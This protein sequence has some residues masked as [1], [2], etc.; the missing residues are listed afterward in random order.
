MKKFYLFAAAATCLAIAC[1]IVETPAPEDA[2]LV[3]YI[4]ADGNENASKSS[5]S[6]SDASFSWNTG[7][8][9]AVH[10][11]AGYKI[12]DGLDGSYDGS[13]AATFAF[14]GANAIADES[15]RESFAIYPASLV[16][17]GT[18][19]LT[20]S[21]SDYTTS[22]LKLT[23]PS[24][25]ALAEVQDEVSPTPMIAVN[26]PDADLSFKALCP[27]LRITVQNIPKQTKRIE[28]NFN[29]Q[30]VQ[31][32]FTLTGVTPGTSAIATGATD[33]DDDIIRVTMAD[34]DS[35][36]DQLV[37]N[38]P[39]PAGTYGNITVSAYDA[40]TD[41]HV[42]LSLTKPIKAGGWTPTRKASRKLTATLPVF[43]SSA[44]K[45]IAIAP[46]NLLDHTMNGG[47]KWALHFFSDQV[48]Y[49]GDSDYAPRYRK[50]NNGNT[51]I[52]YEG[53]LDT[54]ESGPFDLGYSVDL[55]GY[56]VNGTLGVNSSTDSRHYSYADFYDWG[57]SSNIIDDSTSYSF[58]PNT[59]RTP[60]G[61]PGGE[62]EYLLCTRSV[63]NSLSDGARFMMAQIQGYS[64]YEIPYDIY[65]LVIFP[66]S[67]THPA[68]ASIVAPGAYNNYTHSPAVIQKTDWKKM[69]AAGAAFLPDGGYREGTRVTTGDQSGY[70][71][72]STQIY[73]DEPDW[74]GNYNR[75]SKSYALKWEVYEF[76][77]SQKLPAHYGCSV[78]LIRD[79]N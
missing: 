50:Y 57:L 16:W 61:G 43:S 38:L 74:Q 44:M 13:N 32:E 19:I 30:R 22:S 9:I 27:L 69:E 2:Y 52:E 76:K 42:I 11:S 8:K 64:Y 60:S 75:T 17:D 51:H 26:E 36:H 59:W 47:E 71:W 4:R 63:N 49:L 58:A 6:G 31:G 62:W 55:F 10:T 7:D 45:K 1:N 53:V 5:V 41:G 29:G 78:R 70:Y 23:L 77:P 3:T 46:G 68:D 35:W 66:D 12:S 28:F 34:N 37:V 21:A 14:S 56:S 24:S 20:G 15:T 25:Y 67:Y 73:E 40:A 48:F 72:S 65:G 39:V 54:D 79:L 33:D 18:A